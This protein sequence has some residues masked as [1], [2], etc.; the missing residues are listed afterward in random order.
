LVR[1]PDK[2]R[3]FWLVGKVLEL[4]LGF[5]SIVRSAQIKRADGREVFHCIKHLYPLELNVLQP[6]GR[7]NTHDPEVV[8]AVENMRIVK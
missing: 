3:P 4:I 1:L 8:S 2:P 5:D 6:E 7:P